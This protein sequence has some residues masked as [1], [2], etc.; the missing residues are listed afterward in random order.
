[1]A[2]EVIRQSALQQVAKLPAMLQKKG[3]QAANKIYEKT[4][5][6]YSVWT[7]ARLY[8]LDLGPRSFR[9]ITVNYH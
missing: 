7:T 5:E 4:S 1:M 6:G 8:Q 2:S 9:F 3:T